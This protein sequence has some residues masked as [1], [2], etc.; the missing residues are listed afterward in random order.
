MQMT[1]LFRRKTALLL[2]FD[3]SL[4]DLAPDPMQVKVDPLLKEALR[5]IS[6][7]K[8]TPVAIVTG[9]QISVLDGFLELPELPVSG[10]HGTEIRLP[11]SPE[12]VRHAPPIPHML[13][14]SLHSVCKGLD[15]LLED[16]VET[17]VVHAANEAAFYAARNE[18]AAALSESFKGYSLWTAGLSLEIHN[19]SY[20]KVTGIRELMRTEAFKKHK[21][22]YIG[23]DAATY[24]GIEV[25]SG[26]SVS[27][28]NVC[29][30]GKAGFRSASEVRRLLIDY[31]RHG[32]QDN[33]A[34]G[35]I[36]SEFCSSSNR[37]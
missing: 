36:L 9:R 1:D 7:E 20:S 10:N 28:V 35:L 24:P 34:L 4:A 27:L 17:A 37:R 33:T 13:W 11:G 22:V 6:V 16:K 15:C 30:A 3:G 8:K 21:P 12:I 31:S 26:E 18:I 29:A 23:D 32:S 19:G 25:L 2:D 5:R 14:L